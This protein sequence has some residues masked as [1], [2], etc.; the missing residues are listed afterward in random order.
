M[1]KETSTSS[2]DYLEKNQLAVYFEDVVRVMLETRPEDPIDF[3]CEYFAK[4]KTVF[5]AITIYGIYL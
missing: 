2:Q 5:P 4:C 3:I 1:L